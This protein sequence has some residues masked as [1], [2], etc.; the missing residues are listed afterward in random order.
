MLYLPILKTAFNVIINLG[1]FRVCF[2]DVNCHDTDVT[3]AA[4]ALG[5]VLTDQQC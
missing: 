5:R 4:H 2:S 1:P 3:G